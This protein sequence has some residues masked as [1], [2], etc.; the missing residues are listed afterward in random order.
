MRVCIFGTSFHTFALTRLSF[1]HLCNHGAVHR[2]CAAISYSAPDCVTHAWRRSCM[3]TPWLPS[4]AVLR[5]TCT[6]VDNLNQCLADG[7]GH[8]SC[9]DHLRQRAPKA[10][11]RIAACCLLLCL[12]RIWSVQIPTCNC[13][14]EASA[15]HRWLCLSARWRARRAAVKACLQH[16]AT[17]SSCC[18]STPADAAPRPP[19]VSAVTGGVP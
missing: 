7:H 8:C 18:R 4:P 11:L 15:V 2:R 12:L 16:D 9:V 17:A 3:R 10:H 13:A 6:A 5:P 14:G 1:T 19:T